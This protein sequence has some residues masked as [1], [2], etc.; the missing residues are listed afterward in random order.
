MFLTYARPQVCSHSGNQEKGAR[1][2]SQCE[3]GLPM[4]I[5]YAVSVI[6]AKTVFS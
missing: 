5:S 1:E 3:A 2:V 4:F 6:S